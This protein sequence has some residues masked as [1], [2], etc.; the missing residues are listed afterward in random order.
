STRRNSFDESEADLDP[1]PDLEE[2]PHPP[3][4][5]AKEA[6]VDRD[7]RQD[8]QTKQTNTTLYLPKD[9]RV[10]GSEFGKPRSKTVRKEMK[11]PDDEEDEDHPRSGWSEENRKFMYHRKEL[12]DFVDQDPVMRIL[13]LKRITDPK[14]PVTAPVTR[15]NRFDAAMELIRLLKEDVGEVPQSPD[16]LPLATANAVDNLTVS[17]HYASAAEEGSYT[18]SAPPRR[19]SLGPSG[20]SMLEA[21]SKIC[22]SSPVKRSRLDNGPAPTDQ[23]TTTESSDRSVVRAIQIQASDA[24]SSSESGRSGGSD[25]YIDSRCRILFVVNK[26]VTPKVE[27]KSANPDP[28]LLDR[29]HGHQDHN[30]KIH[31]NG[32]NRDRGHPS[33]HCLFVCRGWEELHDMGKC[34]MEE[35][36]N[37][38]RQWFNPTKHM[39]VKLGRSSGWNPIRAERSRYCIYAFVNKTSV[40]QIRSHHKRGSPSN[41]ENHEVIGD[42]K[43]QI[44]GLNLQITRLLRR[45]RGL[46]RS[47]STDGQQP[48]IYYRES[49]VVT[50][51][52]IH[53]IPDKIHNEKAILLLDIGAEVSIVDTAFARKIGCYIDSSQIQD[54]VGI[55]DN[56]YQTEGRTRIKVTPA[57]SLVYFFDIW[58]GDLTDQKIYTWYG[59]YGSILDPLRSSPW[60]DQSAG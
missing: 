44:Y 57:G 3:Q 19:M 25:S 49:L 17:S 56:V 43:I 18:S 32:F 38:I 28:R 55:G 52:I 4:V 41:Q 48:W 40:D 9:T 8:P 39:D 12:R 23:V 5:S 2:K 14:V 59:R 47:R 1:D 20:A 51:I 45:S 15:T 60:I 11:T 37:Q 16:P 50:E 53:Q 31:G 21:R 26:D 42:S 6:P 29:D 33:D 30:M 46:A 13:K 35:F 58:V 34:P 24:G 22:R 10:S 36:Y 27:K 7:S 54:C